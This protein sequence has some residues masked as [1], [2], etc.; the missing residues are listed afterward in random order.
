MEGDIAGP[1]LEAVTNLNLTTPELVSSAL[2]LAAK[3]HE[4]NGGGRLPGRLIAAARTAARKKQNSPYDLT[5][6]H[7][8]ALISSDEGLNALI[9]ERH[10]LKP[11]DPKI[12]AAE[13]MAKGLGEQMLKIW[14]RAPID[15]LPEAPSKT[16]ATG[17]TMRRAVARVGRNEP[18]P[19]GSGKKHKHCCIEKDQERLHHSTSIAGLTDVEL[20]ANPESYLTALSLDSYPAHEVARFDPLKVPPD[21]REFYLANLCRARLLDAC[22]EVFEKLG[23]ND[24]LES[25]FNS[26][27]IRIAQARRKDLVDRM[28]KLPPDMSKVR[29]GAVELFLNEEDPA[30]L[31]DLFQQEALLVLSQNNLEHMKGF[32]R[33][34]LKSNLCAVGILVARG[35]IPLLPPPEAAAL[36]DELLLARD[37]LNLSPDDPISD[38][39][40]KQ[41]VEQRDEGKDAVALREAQT[42][43]NS[44]MQ[45]VQ[46]YRESVERLEKELVRREKQ[47]AAP[48]APVV[49]VDEAALKEMRQKV[50][51]LKSALK[52]RHNE[53]NELRRELQ[54]VQ[55][56]LETLRQNATSAAPEEPEAPD[57][58]EELLL[59]QDA[60][61]VR[62][63]RL[64]EFPKGFQQTLA[65]FPRHIARATIIMTGR[66]AAGEPAAYVGALRLKQV[67]NVMRQR[68][69]TDYRLLFRLH[70][71]HLQVIDLINR[72][73]FDRRLKTLV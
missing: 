25:A 29:L 9:F 64:M 30:K 57:R 69:G 59:P 71:D 23:Y 3:W 66:L 13:E 34:L 10:G 49:P 42:R 65:G 15:V 45:E 38:V 53:R 54:K 73:D 16:L 36:L 51:G 58:E 44:K 46:R 52:E 32:P 41:S 27:L 2:F 63:V 62:P 43:L 40:D 8:V 20:R 48:A 33:T 7:A 60:P 72:K 35:M 55:T 70:P 56:D 22:V 12:K 50:S 14:R 19:C 5:L 28:L 61:E 39:L 18:C 67:P 1:L 21:L 4:E 11:G 17:N 6:L 47:A 26:I 31:M 68:I 37:K 24:K